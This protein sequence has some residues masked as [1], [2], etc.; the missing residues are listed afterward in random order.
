M[1][2]FDRSKI[3]PWLLSGKPVVRLWGKDF[4][5][6]VDNYLAWLL[7]VARNYKIELQLKKLADPP[8]I[9]VRAYLGKPPQDT[10]VDPLF[11]VN[12][13]EMP[14]LFCTVKDCMNRLAKGMPAG[15]IC[16]VH[17]GK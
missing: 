8:G 17:N 11:V 13:Q 12:K 16:E 3:D 4:D 14:W 10:L 15:G 9:V 5:M 6:P 2:T 1:Q 7:E